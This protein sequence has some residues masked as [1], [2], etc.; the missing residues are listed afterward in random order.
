MCSI[1]IDLF[2]KDETTIKENTMAVTEFG[3]AVRKARH[4]TN[5]TLATMSKGLKKSVAFLSAIETGRSKIPLDFVKEIESFFIEKGYQPE[6]DLTV[7]AQIENKNVP[8][9]GLSVQQQMMVA[10]FANSQLSNEQI[11]KISTLLEQIKSSPDQLTL[12][13]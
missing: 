1:L 5:D 13:D 11:Q 4:Q 6:E 10:G 7:L 3:R 8:L 9:D 2:S 12:E